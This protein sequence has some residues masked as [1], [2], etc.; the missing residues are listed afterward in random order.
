MNLRVIFQLV[1]YIKYTSSIVRSDDSEL[2]VLTEVR[3]GDEFRLAIDFIPDRDFFVGDI[4][5]TQFTI[6]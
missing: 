4:P 1:G 2:A 6:E 5:Q 3:R